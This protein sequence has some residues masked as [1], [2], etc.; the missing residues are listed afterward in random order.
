MDEYTQI[1]HSPLEVIG[2]IAALV[3]L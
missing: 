2:R 3:P 1:I